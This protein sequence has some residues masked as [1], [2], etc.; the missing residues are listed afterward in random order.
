MS[1][2]T[3]KKFWHDWLWPLLFAVIVVKFI[4]NPFLLE[5]YEVPTGSMEKTIL[6]GDRLFAEK[7]TYGIHIP[8]TDKTVLS[9]ASP[10]PGQMVIF[11]SPYDG[12]T[13]VK[14]CIGLPGDTIEVKHK[15][16][17]LNGRKVEQKFIQHTD[18]EEYPFP[19][20]AVNPK[21]VQG[22]WESGR[23]ADRYWVRDNFG[24]VVVPPDCYFMMGDNRD[25]S[26]DSRYW[27]PLPKKNIRGR[28]MFIYW[29]WD[30]QSDI[31]LGKFW[32]RFRVKR[33][34]KILA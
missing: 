5:A 13:L 24:P 23:N 14:R 18:L 34:G 19:Q 25:E 15:D 26:F 4:I 32:Q 6:P 27:G 29:S 30:K 7:F 22:D 11:R 17:Y 21:A 12:L 28:V 1:N 8:F 20:A 2:K 33:I 9:M 31:P 16:L 10:R 3:F